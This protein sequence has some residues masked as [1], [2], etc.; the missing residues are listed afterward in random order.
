MYC[1]IS[2]FLHP[3]KDGRGTNPY[4]AQL[5]KAAEQSRYILGRPT[6]WGKRSRWSKDPHLKNRRFG[7]QTGELSQGS[8]QQ[9]LNKQGNQTCKE[10]SRPCVLGFVDS[11]EVSILIKRM[12]VR[13][14][15]FYNCE[16]LLRV[17]KTIIPSFSPLQCLN[18]LWELCICLLNIH[19]VKTDLGLNLNFST[20]V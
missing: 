14:V 4:Q 10:F 7:P 3:E 11:T 9:L 6:E 17:L 16:Q 13:A 2:R 5:L 8:K 1:T 20:L 18:S 15:H 19:E 12:S